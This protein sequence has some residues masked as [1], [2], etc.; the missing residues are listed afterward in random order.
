[1]PEGRKGQHKR[2]PKKIE[3][4]Y[5]NWF[6][7]IYKDYEN[8]GDFDNLPGKGKPLPEDLLKRDA[9]DG[10]L[11]DA[12]YLHPWIELQHE[13]RDEISQLIDR[14]QIENRSFN[15]EVN[16]INDKIRKYNRICPPSLQKWLINPDNIRQQYEQWK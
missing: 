13:I 5:G 7:A 11:K 8:K 10:V 6:D 9:L 3:Q 14:L 15:E 2:T 1:M 4:E 12:N 16:K